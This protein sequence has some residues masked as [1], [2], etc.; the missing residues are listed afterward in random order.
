MTIKNV[1]ST[2]VWSGLVFFTVQRCLIGSLPAMKRDIFTTT[3]KNTSEYAVEIAEIAS[4]GK[5]KHSYLA[6]SSRPFL[7]VSSITRG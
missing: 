7:F 3:L 4:A 2:F 1:G 6:L 5:K